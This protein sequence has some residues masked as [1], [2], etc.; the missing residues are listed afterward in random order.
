MDESKGLEDIIAAKSSITSINGVMLTYRGYKIDD[1]MEK[2][3]FEE[4]AYLL[5]Y[6]KLPN[7]E[8][9]K[10]FKREL[11]DF[12]ELSDE[13]I[14]IMLYL[15]KECNFIDALRVIISVLAMYE[16]EVM[17]FSKKANL[18][19]SKFLLAQISPIVCA[20]YRIRN[21]LQPIRFNSN[22]SYAANFL[23]ML[24]GKIPNEISEKAFN[25]ALIIHADH[26]LNA[27]TFSARV[28]VAT[29]SDIYSGIISA[30]GTLKGSL[31]GGANEEVMSML[32][33]IS[34]ISNVENYIDI[35]IKNK[36]K[37][38][39]MGHRVYKK[40]DPRTKHLKV[41]AKELAEETGN[42]KCYDLSEKI[43]KYVFSKKN[44]MPNVDFYS[45]SVYDYLGISK[46]LFTP[47]FVISRMSGW[48]A[49][50]MEQYE[51]NK[52]FRPRSDYIGKVNQEYISIDKR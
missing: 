3:E 28:T 30:I 7:H 29:L 40:G 13:I 51:N 25:K 27:S 6:G 39:G 52:I 48:T 11:A 8:E 5:W 45:A 31:H 24:N 20:L 42:M 2:A 46:E 34:D 22:L 23:Y 9:Y 21:N 17:D 47:I 18:K 44:L 15:P 19:K 43:E 14:K 26:E 50:I 35:K 12:S 16:N 1:L 38:M 36:E 37:I 49:H 32:E 41:I 4:V 33:E 10:Y